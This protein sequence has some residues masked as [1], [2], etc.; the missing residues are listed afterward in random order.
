M[1]T[2]VIQRRDGK[3]GNEYRQQEGEQ[4][5]IPAFGPPVE[6]T[7]GNEKCGV[8]TPE[9]D[10]YDG[11]SEEE[12]GKE[13]PASHPGKRASREKQSQ[14][15]EERQTQQDEADPTTIEP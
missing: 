3:E 9:I 4:E 10:A 2:T 13:A 11:L 5:Q 14:V 6:R 7:A 12:Y 15:T 8:G 1:E